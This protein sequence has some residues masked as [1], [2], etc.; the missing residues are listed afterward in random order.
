MELKLQSNNAQHKAGGVLLIEPVW[1]RNPNLLEAV[2]KFSKPFNRTSMELKPMWAR[3][4]ATLQAAPFNRTSMESK[5]DEVNGFRGKVVAF[6]RTSME[7]KPRMRCPLVVSKMSLLI[8]PV[9]N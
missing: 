2:L 8:E 1:N 6:N 5:R 3:A 7:S 9:W 4:S